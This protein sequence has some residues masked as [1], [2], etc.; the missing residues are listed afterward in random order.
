[1][2]RV[3]ALTLALLVLA[4]PGVAHEHGGI[5]GIEQVFAR[6]L[7]EHNVQRASIAMAYG[8]RLVLAKGYGGLTPESRVLI[9]SLSK[10]ITGV[11]VATLIQD[12]K[13]R[14][15]TTLGEVLERMTPEPP[16]PHDARL[17]T[18]T[19][20]QM[21]THR[22]GFSRTG[23]DPAT[24]PNL[25]EV[26]VHRPVNHAT[27]NDLFPGVLATALEFA[28]G[29]KHVYTN[30]PHL[31]LGV[32]V[33]ALTGERYE[34]YCGATVLRPHGI[35]KPTLHERWAVLGA[36]GG[37]NLSGPE[38]LAFY[39]ALAPTS[40]VLTRETRAWM[41]APAG[42]ETGNGPQFYSMLFVR[43]APRNGHQFF[44][45]GSWG[46]RLPATSK[47]GLINDSIG[48]RAIRTPSGVS[49]F[50]SYEPR[51]GGDALEALDRELFRAVAAVTVWPETDLF[52]TFGLK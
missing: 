48:T 40:S 2:T 7:K 8:D 42:K 4:L 31:L 35:K 3:L 43:P 51:P 15:D 24:G 11:C 17:R 20:E 49:W 21:L 5:D 27:M 19:I 18:V 50:V 1:V 26:L 39:K 12:G 32:A 37:W 29:T 6:W 34:D 36:F 13:L 38:Y 28:P 44:H 25:G 33:E 47:S 10:A 41:L 16:A 46:Y 22:T 30:A 14:F 9:A 45:A 52:P 23:G